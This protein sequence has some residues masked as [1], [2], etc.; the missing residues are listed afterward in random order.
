V[1]LNE[2]FPPFRLFKKAV[3]DVAFVLYELGMEQVTGRRT[4]E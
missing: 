2:W 1:T 3:P 4:V